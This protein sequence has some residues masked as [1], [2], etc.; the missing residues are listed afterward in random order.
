MLFP[1]PALNSRT[2]ILSVSQTYPQLHLRSRIA[3]PRNT[4]DDDSVCVVFYV[5]SI[6]ANTS[7]SLHSKFIH[8]F[9]PLQIELELLFRFHSQFI[10]DVRSDK[11]RSC[12]VI[13]NT[14]HSTA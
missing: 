14:L 4:C 6:Y 9:I 11:S 10:M 7:V 5:S 2:Q 3:V 12:D 8:S 1:I 13:L